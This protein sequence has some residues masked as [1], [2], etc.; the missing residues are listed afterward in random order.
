[1]EAF[2]LLTRNYLNWSSG[3]FNNGGVTGTWGVSFVGVSG[4]SNEFLI[5]FNSDNLRLSRRF[6]R[7]LLEEIVK[8]ASEAIGKSLSISISFLVSLLTMCCCLLTFFVQSDVSR[9]FFLDFSILSFLS[10]MSSIKVKQT[11]TGKSWKIGKKSHILRISNFNPHVLATLLNLSFPQE[12][13]NNLAT[14][15]MFTFIHCVH[16]KT[17][18][19]GRLDPLEHNNH[20]RI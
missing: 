7:F 9:S 19:F 12:N 17:N 8:V 2:D 5:I 11:L 1:M 16:K 14:F 20:L 3:E 10:V 18:I 13:K 15:H 4:L 6:R